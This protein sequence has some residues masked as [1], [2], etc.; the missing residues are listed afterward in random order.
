MDKSMSVPVNPAEQRR[1]PRMAI[2]ISVRVIAENR[3]PGHGRGHEVSNVGM[4]VYV[5]MDLPIGE[6]VRLNFT[7]PHS[8][9]KF[10]ITAIVRNRE[11]FRYG[12]ELKE[13]TPQESMELSRVTKILELMG[14]AR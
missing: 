4:A 14:N 1:S 11:G 8:R 10:D 3:A 13:L 12:V 2:D 7:L 9:L 6:Q 5:G